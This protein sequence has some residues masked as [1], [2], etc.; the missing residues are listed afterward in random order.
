M[1][2]ASVYMFNQ[3]SL[4]AQIIINSGTPFMINGTSDSAKWVPQTSVQT[5]QTP[6]TVP[7]NF[8]AGNNV[9]LMN[10][11]ANQFYKYNLLIDNPNPGSIELYIFFYDKYQTYAGIMML[12]EGGPLTEPPTLIGPSPTASDI[13]LS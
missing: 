2:T 11:G 6:G 12:Y 13:K 8:N 4:N 1:T 10:L 7:G 9:L 5:F 3:T